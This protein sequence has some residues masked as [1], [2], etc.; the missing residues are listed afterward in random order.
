MTMV[1]MLARES[2]LQQKSRPG[3]LLLVLLSGFALVACHFMAAFV[4]LA[5]L[6]A[7]GVRFW[8][9]RKLDVA[10]ILCYI[11]PFSVLVVY[12]SKIS[13]YETLIFPRSFMPAPDT[14]LIAY[15]V[16]G[17]YA[18]L[19]FLA[20]AAIVSGPYLVNANPGV[21]TRSSKKSGK[22]F[23]TP[24]RTLLL[25]L[26]LE[27]VVAIAAIWRG[28]GAF[29]PRYG[30]PAT[31]PM[32]I[33]TAYVLHAALRNSK[34]AGVITICLLGA[35]PAYRVLTNPAWLQPGQ[36]A[37]VDP[38][39]GKPDYHSVEPDLP[40]VVASGL[41]YVEMNHRESPAFLRR[42]YYLTDSAAAAEYAHATLFEHEEAIREMFHFQAEVEPLRQ[43]E[44][45]HRKFLVLGT[46]D[47]PE[48]WLLRKMKADGDAIRF[49]GN[50]AT[51]YKDGRLY[52]VTLSQAAS[53]ARD[54]RSHGQSGA[55]NR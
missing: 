16:L 33:G 49:L 23:L 25:V 55:P 30:L 37:G 34:L 4:L 19:F 39:P 5:F 28:H 17:Y 42:V 43:F 44:S 50:Y 14:P 12:H 38:G 1:L 41:T 18:W 21:R 27:P 46:F 35:H 54:H 9:S 22:H 8:Q 3:W 6:A 31:I 45:E 20:G 11:L 7:E 10:L 29:F 40:F 32:A 2:D 36:I 53:D 26:F 13:G 51:S 48:D 47:Y 52:E 24:E 15:V